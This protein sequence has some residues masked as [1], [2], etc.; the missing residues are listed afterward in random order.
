M[1]VDE[2]LIGELLSV[3]RLTTSTVATGEVSSLYPHELVTGLAVIVC[4]AVAV[5]TC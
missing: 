4:V 2:G 1:L 3:D 5:P